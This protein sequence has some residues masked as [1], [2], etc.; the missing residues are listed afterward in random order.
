MPIYIPLG[1][2]Y[3][4]EQALDFIKIIA[5]V[6]HSELPNLTSMERLPEHRYKKV[7]LDCYQN[8]IGQTVA[9][10]YCVRPKDGAPVSAPLLWEELNSDFTPCDFNIKNILPRIEKIGDIWA[11]VLGP[12]INMKKCINYLTKTFNL[13]NE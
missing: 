4:H 12:G 7:Y 5:S 1:S 3:T 11:G 2:K 10:P 13:I 8:R 9:A 6:I